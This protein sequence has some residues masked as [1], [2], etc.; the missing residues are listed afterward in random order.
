MKVSKSNNRKKENPFKF[1]SIKNSFWVHKVSGIKILFPNFHKKLSSD[2]WKKAHF[3]SPPLWKFQSP[4][5]IEKK[6]I[7]LILI[8][9]KIPFGCTK[10]VALR[11][12][13]P[14]FHEKLLSG[15]WKK[16]HFT[17]PP[18]WKFSSLNVTAKLKKKKKIHLILIQFKI[19]FECTKS[20]ALGWYSQDFTKKL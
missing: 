7:H 12:Y 11:Y 1:D 17:S 20:L 15:F 4:N 10:L 2:F 5:V 6:K 3:T 13:F 8:Q 14:N 16:G 19:P 18:L 9:S